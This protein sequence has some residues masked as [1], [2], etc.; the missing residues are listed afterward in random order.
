MNDIIS[1]TTIY[2]I[3]ETAVLLVEGTWN[4]SNRSSVMF[5]CALSPR[6]SH[7]KGVSSIL[8]PFPVLRE[9]S[10]CL[11]LSLIWW[12][13]QAWQRAWHLI[14]LGRRSA[15]PPAL[16]GEITGAFLEIGKLNLKPQPVSQSHPP[17]SFIPSD[18]HFCRHRRPWWKKKIQKRPYTTAAPAPILSRGAVMRGNWHKLAIRWAWLKWGVGV[19]GIYTPSAPQC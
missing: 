15:S 6:R 18:T 16:A 11:S 1:T 17:G 12:G 3:I 14:T 9:D 7:L 10:L 4:M 2:S 8:A 19:W 5:S 13:C